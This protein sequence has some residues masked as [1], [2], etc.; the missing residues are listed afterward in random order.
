ML[1][2]GAPLLTSECGCALGRSVALR[3]SNSAPTG[4]RVSGQEAVDKGVGDAGLGLDSDHPAHRVRPRRVRLFPPIGHGRAS[5]CRLAAACGSCDRMNKVDLG[6]VGCRPH[7]RQA[8]TRDARLVHDHLVHRRLDALDRPSKRS[9]V[10]RLHVAIRD[11]DHASR[12]V[13]GRD[14]GRIRRR[15]RLGSR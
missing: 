14:A 12:G 7:E 10:R 15:S 4:K 5:G 3:S 1:R 13:G 2:S 6:G 11:L 8:A 9:L